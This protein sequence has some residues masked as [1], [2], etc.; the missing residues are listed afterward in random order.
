M[1]TIGSGTFGTV[2]LCRY[3]PTNEYFCIKILNKD[4]IVKLKQQEH[5]RSEKA[6]LTDVSHPFIVNL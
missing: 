5:V 2:K 1:D 4:K 6:I 3:N